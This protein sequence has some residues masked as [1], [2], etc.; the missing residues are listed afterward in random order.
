MFASHIDSPK[1]TLAPKDQ[2]VV[3]NGIVSFFCKASGN[4]APDVHWRKGGKRITTGRQRYAVV[5][6]PHGSVLRVE[7]V[8]S[9]R[10]DSILE[11]V[12]DNGIGE[13]AVA[14]VKL[15]VYP[16][17]HS[18]SPARRIVILSASYQRIDKI[19]HYFNNLTMFVRTR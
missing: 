9:K 15:E 2:I 6:M 14:T 3:D 13:P 16:E 17:G 11:C 4:P 18:E 8:K 7:P 19:A 5:S 12:A 10:D 1:I